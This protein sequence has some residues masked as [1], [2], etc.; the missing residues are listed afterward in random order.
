M[1]TARTDPHRRSSSAASATTGRQPPRVASTSDG[2][3]DERGRQHDRPGAGVV[4]DRVADA[5]APHEQRPDGEGD[6][7]VL[8]RR[9]SY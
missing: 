3:H 6:A 7:P 8:A 5:S 4:G 2:E 9:A 1:S